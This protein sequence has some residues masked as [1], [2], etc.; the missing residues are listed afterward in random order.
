MLAPY[1]TVV[2]RATRLALPSPSILFTG[3]QQ[4]SCVM[5]FLSCMQYTA[6]HAASLHLKARLSTAWHSTAQHSTAQHSTAQHSTAQR[7]AAHRPALLTLSCT[8]NTHALSQ[9]GQLQAYLLE[10]G[11]LEGPHPSCS[12]HLSRHRM[13]PV[14]ASQL[15][16][17]LIACAPA[18]LL[19]PSPLATWTLHIAWLQ[20]TV[21]Q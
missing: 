15:A 14:A 8:G 10:G 19:L 17:L 18:P 7:T 5:C 9:G 4:H 1:T 13:S 20:H 11:T 21:H 3:I 6:R 12:P 16:L 2:V